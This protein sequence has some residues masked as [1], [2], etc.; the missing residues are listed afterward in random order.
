MPRFSAAGTWNCPRCTLQNGASRPVCEACGGP[1]VGA[2]AA[3]G[4]GH[5]AE[6]GEV[7]VPARRGRLLEWRSARELRDAAAADAGLAQLRAPAADDP[8]EPLGC[9]GVASVAGF[10]A[11]GGAFVGAAVQYELD[12]T[13]DIDLGMGVGALVGLVLGIIMA[14]RI[15]REQALQLRA[16]GAAGR[17][18]AIGGGDARRQATRPW[19][20]LE[21][22]DFQPG[23]PILPAARAARRVPGGSLSLSTRLSQE[24][25]ARG[26]EDAEAD[27]RM[28]ATMPAADGLIRAL[29]THKVTTQELE[30]APAEH[31]AC[32]ICFE[33]FCRGENQRTLPCFHRFHVACVDQWLRRNGSCPICKH[34]VDADLALQPL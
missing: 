3:G 24:R 1:R 12:G 7:Q 4:G 25:R 33:E 19:L 2:G 34:R 15:D 14:I 30:N 31:R 11:F 17:A 13:L 18:D 16:G 32:T 23:G 22:F 8:E 5:A 20:D 28:R 27:R 6:E 10:C 29:P 21:E 26:G 9:T